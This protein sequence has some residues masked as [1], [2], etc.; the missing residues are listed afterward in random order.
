[1][2]MAFKL[3]LKLLG[4]LLRGGAR[5]SQRFRNQITRPRTVEIRCKDGAAQHYVFANRSIKSVAG[6]AAKADVAVEFESPAQGLRV[7]LSTKLVKRLMDELLDEKIVVE[8]NIMLL[9]WFQGLAQMVF[10]L[11]TP[12][13]LDHT[14]PDAYITHRAS[15]SVSKRITREPER[16]ELPA[17]QTSAHRVRAELVMTMVNA[18]KMEPPEF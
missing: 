3:L 16:Y 18:G 7:L 10:P 12:P 17:E 2:M 8:G 13:Q 5:F 15:P 1:M 6:R 4:L 14:P 9:L 11:T